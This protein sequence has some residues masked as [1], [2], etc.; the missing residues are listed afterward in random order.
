MTTFDK[1]QLQNGIIDVAGGKGK[2][3]IELALTHQMLSTVVDPNPT[4]FS[5]FTSRRIVTAALDNITL[6]QSTITKPSRCMTWELL[7]EDVRSVLH[8]NDAL[9]IKQYLQHYGPK[10]H[11]CLF[12]AYYHSM[13]WK[14]SEIVI[15]M[16]PDEATE[17]IVD[18]AIL[19]Q[20]SFAVVPC[21]VFPT[22][23]PNRL[24]ENQPV[25]TLEEFILYL[26]RKHPLI[27]ETILNFH[28]CNRVLYLKQE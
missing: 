12:D 23:F 13:E 5:I 11:G 1:N 28:G 3:S 25:R 14:S 27:Q 22:L 20:K 10:F 21:C 9:R 24:L 4:K 26:K 7:H 6:P 19:H 8:A 16:H 18:W 2:L 15:G 17:A